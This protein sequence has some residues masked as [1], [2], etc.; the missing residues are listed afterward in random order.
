MALNW[1]KGFLILA[2]IFCSVICST[3]NV[4]STTYYWFKK[5][6]NIDSVYYHT[7][8]YKS[9][10]IKEEGWV[11]SYCKNNDYR[12][13][14]NNTD[15]DCFTSIEEPVGKNLFYHRNG[16]I[17]YLIESPIYVN[18]TGF[19]TIYNSKG[20]IISKDTFVESPIVIIKCNPKK[21]VWPNYPKYE[22]FHF[23]NYSKGRVK[24]EGFFI[25]DFEKTGCWKTY[26]KNGEVKKEHYYLNNK[27]I[28]RTC[29]R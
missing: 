12:T 6:N 11:I 8:Y 1:M 27:L 22:Y 17:E 7:E 14:H 4:D 28:D 2:L 10:K 3:Q 29:N 23:I 19:M 20:E 21:R 15:Y 16:T 9:G 18:D 26:N 25:N 13:I 5:D 24:S